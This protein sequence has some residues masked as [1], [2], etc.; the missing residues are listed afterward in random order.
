MSY[1]GLAATYGL[2]RDAVRRALARFEQV[3]VAKAG[4]PLPPPLRP[5]PTPPTVVSFASWYGIRAA[6]DAPGT[7]PATLR[8]VAAA[9]SPA[10]IQQESTGTQ[11]ARSMLARSTRVRAREDEHP[12]DLTPAGSFWRTGATP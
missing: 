1:D 7:P 6:T 2:T 3:A 10:T 8:E 12:E 5:H 11:E 9:T 4:R